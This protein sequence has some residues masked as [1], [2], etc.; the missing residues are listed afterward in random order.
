MFFFL[1][2][3]REANIIHT[4]EGLWLGPIPAFEQ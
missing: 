2:S 4:T 3:P 1:D